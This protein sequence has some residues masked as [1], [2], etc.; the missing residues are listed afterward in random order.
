[1]KQKGRFGAVLWQ[2]MVVAV[3]VAVGV[4]AT[5]F[6]L[7]KI[8]KEVSAL[9]KQSAR[10]FQRSNQPDP[11]SPDIAMGALGPGGTT[12]KTEIGTETSQKP[13]SFKA[14][15]LV[16]T[17][18]SP[19][20]V[21]CL[22]EV[23]RQHP[24]VLAVAEIQMEI[25]M[26]ET[27]RLVV[28]VDEGRLGVVKI[29]VITDGSGEDD[30]F[31]VPRQFHDAFFAL[32]PN[33]ENLLIKESA[34]QAN[35]HNDLAR[36]LSFCFSHPL[37]TF[38]RI[39]Q[40]AFQTIIS[41]YIYNQCFPS[42]RRLELA[43]GRYITPRASDTS[44]PHVHLAKL[45]ITN[46]DIQV[47]QIDLFQNFPNLDYLALNSIQ[48]LHLVYVSGL[49]HPTTDKIP[50]TVLLTYQCPNLTEITVS[51]EPRQTITKI[52]SLVDLVTPACTNRLRLQKKDYFLN[53]LEIICCPRAVLSKKA[54]HRSIIF[55][56]RSGEA[57]PAPRSGAQDQCISGCGC[58]HVFG[59]LKR[60]SRRAGSVGAEKIA[61]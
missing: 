13:V 35:A 7:K 4:H 18:P 39:E 55:I 46:A 59:G 2:A 40:V 43:N 47:F 24:K 48:N 32:F 8:K 42:L 60:L 23:S 52:G 10:V 53:H 28:R 41:G 45:H 3:S 27:R 6:S 26:D 54:Y 5:G 34:L 30:Q 15:T 61:E 14:K 33:L 31:F 17:N 9:T 37:V 29:K 19:M 11:S 25:T 57:A 12:A 38:L 49:R 1:M 50:L 16:V 44:A 20:M 51:I 21:S 56:N 58:G 22:I 36:N